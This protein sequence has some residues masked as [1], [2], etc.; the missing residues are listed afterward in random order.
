MLWSYR[1]ILLS[2]PSVSRARVHT[3]SHRSSDERNRF[4]RFEEEN[5]LIEIFVFEQILG[6]ELIEPV[7]RKELLFVPVILSI[8]TSVWH[9]F[10]E[11]IKITKWQNHSNWFSEYSLRKRRG[12]KYSSACSRKHYFTIAWENIE[13]SLSILIEEKI[14]GWI[15]LLNKY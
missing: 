8:I 4:Q 2:F 5:L 13:I 14:Q 15:L 9:R 12:K 6:E 1:R 11:K 3:H 7:N 10:V